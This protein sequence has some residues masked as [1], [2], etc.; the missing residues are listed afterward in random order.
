MAYVGLSD[1]FCNVWRS[2]AVQR[3]RPAQ[4]VARARH[5][6]HLQD[7]DDPGTRARSV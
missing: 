5:A 7:D 6:V 1:Y 3:H 4:P 2:L